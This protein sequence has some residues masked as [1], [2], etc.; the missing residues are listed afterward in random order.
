M[1]F[2]E[3]EDTP[4]PKQHAALKQQGTSPEVMSQQVLMQHAGQE[5]KPE[6]AASAGRADAA[7]D[8]AA[9]V[10]LLLHC[11]NAEMAALGLSTLLALAQCKNHIA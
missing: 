6:A 2:A 3:D 11:T 9:L 8:D 4:M 7:A 1:L 5:S 10:I